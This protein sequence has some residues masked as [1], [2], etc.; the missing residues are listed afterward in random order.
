[1]L[2]T[3]P[4]LK[5][6]DSQKPGP[7]ITIIAGTHGDEICGVKA[8]KKVIPNIKLKKGKVYFIL[9]NIKAIKINRR[10]YQY[11]LNRLY[12]DDSLID[13]K[14]KQ[15]Y[16]YKRSREIMQYLN[17]SEALLDIHSSM[18]KNSTPFAICEKPF[19][20]IAK[21]LPVKI[22]ATGFATIEPGGTDDYMFSKGKVGI[23]IECGNHIS[24]L[25]DYNAIES[26][27]RFLNYFNMV[28]IP[29]VKI[30]NVYSIYKTKNN[31]KPIK[32]FKDFE[33]IKK[34]NL[35]GY[36]GNKKIISKKD[37]FILFARKR[38]KSNKE[39]FILGSNT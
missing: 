4:G 36:D 8:F 13:N 27:Y 9:G 23:C 16:E 38:T 14:T 10:Q 28:D 29:S 25:S 7:I 3:I 21:V 5:V 34:G 37:N 24:D 6:I 26:I 17:N 1:M 15:T 20:K 31:F 12:K 32:S 11:N 30:V 19:I 35:I 33:Q 18:S 2:K 22:I 39:A